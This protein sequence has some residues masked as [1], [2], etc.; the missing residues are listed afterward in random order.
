M[1]IPDGL[2]DRWNSLAPENQRF[3]ESGLQ[4]SW[5][6]YDGHVPEESG[7]LYHSWENHIVSYSIDAMLLGQMEGL[8]RQE[9][10]ILGHA[11]PFH[12]IDYL[13][14]PTHYNGNERNCAWKARR[15]MLED[16]FSLEDSHIGAE[17]IIETYPGRKAESKLGKILAAADFLLLKE[18]PSEFIR[19]NLYVLAEWSAFPNANMHKATRTLADYF[20]A[21]EVFLGLRRFYVDSANEICEKW[22][23]PNIQMLE[24]LNKVFSGVD[25]RTATL[26][27]LEDTLIATVAEFDDKPLDRSAIHRTLE[28]WYSHRPRIKEINN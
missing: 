16:M 25:E 19:Q 2:E 11:A 4:S 22:R 9:M 24:R 27:Q 7:L 10:R 28:Y 23:K 5:E 18:R 14:G 15:V 8:S 26:E 13:S 12:D 3:L 6:H 17:A 21:Q 1:Y 20:G